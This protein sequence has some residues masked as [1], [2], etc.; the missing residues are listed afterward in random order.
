MIMNAVSRNLHCCEAAVG[1]GAW[2]HLAADALELL[3]V[4]LRRRGRVRPGALLQRIVLRL[5][6]SD[7]LA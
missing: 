1:G 2:A 6:R 7:A 4:R 5:Q 3:R